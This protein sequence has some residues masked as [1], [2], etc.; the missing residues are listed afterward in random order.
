MSST[1]RQKCLR[2]WVIRTVLN[3]M[4]TL[5]CIAVRTLTFV[6]IVIPRA[7]HTVSIMHICTDIVTRLSANDFTMCHFQRAVLHKCGLSFAVVNNREFLQRNVRVIPNPRL[8]V[9]KHLQNVQ[10]VGYIWQVKE[11]RRLV[12]K[13]TETLIIKKCPFNPQNVFFYLHTVPQILPWGFQIQ[14]NIFLIK[15]PTIIYFTM[16]CFVPLHVFGGSFVLCPS[17]G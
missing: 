1:T 11:S 4:T 6:H 15:N 16:L 8:H 2:C 9:Q 13:N 17:W 12:M 10:H 7:I 3:V 5:K 14:I